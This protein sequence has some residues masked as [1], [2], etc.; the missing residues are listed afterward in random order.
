MVSARIRSTNKFRFFPTAGILSTRD[1]VKS[2]VLTMVQVKLSLIVASPPL[3]HLSPIHVPRSP[4][5]NINYRKKKRQKR[6]F[7]DYIM[8]CE[9][10]TQSKLLVGCEKKCKNDFSLKRYKKWFFYIFIHSFSFLPIWFRFQLITLYKISWIYFY[11]I[12]MI[13]SHLYLVY[14]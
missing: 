12:F 5:T 13:N 8:L 3:S 7:I 1:S 11:M 9:S 2:I 14:N 10:D 4:S 6:W